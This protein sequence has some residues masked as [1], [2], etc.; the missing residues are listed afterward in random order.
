M[1]LRELFL[2]IVEKNAKIAKL[3]TR[4]NLVPHGSCDFV[5]AFVRVYYRNTPNQKL[6]S[7]RI[8]ELISIIVWLA[9]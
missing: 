8:V 2:R 9:H 1:F 6:S 7:A 5:G 3:R 4:K